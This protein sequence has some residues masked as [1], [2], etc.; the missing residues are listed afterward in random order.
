MK[1]VTVVGAG[2]SGLTLAYYLQRMGLKPVVIEK[3]SH[4]GGL[5]SSTRTEYGLVESAANALLADASMEE[6]FHDLRVEF[7]ERI[8]ARSKRYIYWGRPRK[9]P[10]TF[11]ASL[12]ALWGLMR[13]A[14]GFASV[15]PKESETIKDWATRVFGAQFEERLLSPALQGIYAGDPERLSASLV[16]KSMFGSKRRGKL[17]G[18]VSPKNG[19][20]EL[21]ESL[22]SRLIKDGAIIK[23]D[24]EYVL[25]Q[26]LEQPTVICTSAWSAAQ[27]LQSYDQQL[28]E[29][30]GGCNSLP[31]V[32]T[33]V[34]FERHQDDIEGFGCLFPQSQDFKSLGVLF[35]SCIFEERSKLRSE[36]WIMGGF[37]RPEVAT[38]K[39]Q[40]ILEAILSDRKKMTG[41][42]DRPASFKVNR[43]PR[44][45][46]H[47]TVDWEQALAKLEV[48]PP[49]YLHGNYLGV[50]GLARICARSKELAQKIK[51][52]Y[53]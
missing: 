1:Q 40:E 20:G 25:P 33:T 45:L 39:D 9:W 16:I 19:M 28:S 21:L 35:N 32:S 51:E 47:Y 49:L 4:C 48:K 2:F 36:T 17:K 12:R 41:R 14:F 5:I 18:S 11:A 24:L 37:S 22:R 8:P 30:L 46:P 27:L 34:F 31:V 3:Q 52:S 7:A 23:T 38:L 44:A 10:L 53:G 50:I 43:W 29:L 6:L 15:R 42:E 26:K 13:F